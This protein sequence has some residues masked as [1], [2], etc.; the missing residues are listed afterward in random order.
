MSFSPLAS[1]SDECL[2][3]CAKKPPHLRTP[4]YVELNSDSDSDV[5]FVSSETCQTPMTEITITNNTHL[6][7]ANNVRKSILSALTAQCSETS[8]NS[9]RKRG[10]NATD[11]S[12]PYTSQNVSSTYEAKPSTSETVLQ[13]LIQSPSEHSHHISPKCM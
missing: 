4:E 10:R 1:D 7:S 2:F 6:Q 13:W 9:K 11:T 3:V 12:S 5:V 8:T